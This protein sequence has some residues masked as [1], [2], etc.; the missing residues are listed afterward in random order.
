MILEIQDIVSK[1]DGMAHVAFPEG[2]TLGEVFDH[3]E[4]LRAFKG[5]ILQIIVNGKTVADWRGL[6]PK[7]SDKVRM[8][9]M[10][11]DIG[12]GAIIAIIS[13][14]VSVTQLF[15]G[16]FSKPK[17]PKEESG[18]RDS[19]SFGFQ[20]IR[21]T[22]APGGVVP[23]N[24]GVHRL[25]G[26]VLMY[27][28][29]VA[30]DRRGQEMAMLLSLG[31]GTV[32]SITCVKINNLFATDIESL[33]IESRLGQTSQS[34]MSG[35]DQ[36][37]NTFFDGREISTISVIY[38]NVGKEI[39]S[40]DLQ[41]V[42]PGGLWKDDLG[43]PNPKRNPITVFYTVETR[44]TGAGDFTDVQTRAFTAK[45]FDDVYDNF[46]VAFP[47][48]GQWDLR[49]TWVGASSNN[50]TDQTQD[51]NDITLKNVTE[52]QVLPSNLNDLS[53]SGTALLGI[54]AAA[55]AQL[56]GGRPNVTALVYGRDVR[57]YDSEDSFSVLF[58][59][60]P[61]WHVIDYLTNSVYGMGRYIDINDIN[62]Q[63]FIDFG[64][65]CDSQV[66]VCS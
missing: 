47:S 40:V 25:G 18:P 17:S 27:R 2:L 21:D 59:Q 55:T 48:A 19:P 41:V 30:A 5:Q 33:S 46:G 63:S 66:D 53:F 11:K 26:Q 24:F 61:A 32:S 64:T 29:E 43:P 6:C 60:N 34:V 62:I 31:E 1:E 65:F 8:L 3:E 14:V 57:V 10:P 9:F 4:T 15:I 44:A 49:V 12:I 36:I 37:R 28:V 22:F 39:E 23:V 16:L 42:A 20:G 13:A 56:H 45:A 58:T 38:T 54:S 35:F 51:K 7:K 52:Y 50:K